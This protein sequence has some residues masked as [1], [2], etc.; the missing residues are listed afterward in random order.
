MRSRSLSRLRLL[1]PGTCAWIRHGGDVACYDRRADEIRMPERS[2]FIG[3]GTC[4]PIEA[5][6]ST[7]LHELA[8]WSGSP[9]R[10][11]REFGRRFGDE[12]Y[13]MEE[14]VAELGAAFLC[15]QLKVTCEPRP[16]HAAYLASWLAVL[17]RD[18][19][20][21]FTVASLAQDAAEYLEA[22]EEPPRSNGVLSQAATATAPVHS[23]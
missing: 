17:G 9:K 10:L 15:T 18:S 22:L 16:D 21:I 23:N 8:H 13:A 4:A 20:A 19:R 1:S 7:L 3:S 2:R 5:Y 6:Y 12:A 14:L 11:D